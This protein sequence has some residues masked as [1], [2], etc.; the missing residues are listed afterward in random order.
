MNQMKYDHI[1]TY[2]LNIIIICIVKENQFKFKETQLILS[3]LRSP[4]E[5]LKN[6]IVDHG[7]IPIYRFLRRNTSGQ[8]FVY[9]YSCTLFGMYGE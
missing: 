5:L 6:R 1:P 7:I 2:S 4:M 8:Q 3:D 9:N